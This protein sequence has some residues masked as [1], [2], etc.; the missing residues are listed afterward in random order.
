[1]DKL[2]AWKKREPPRGD[3]DADGERKS[4][5]EA[6]C[7]DDADADW[8][9]PGRRAESVVYYYTGRGLEH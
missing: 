1:M 7:R 2:I 4:L 5:E 9:T 8:L 6:L 3:G